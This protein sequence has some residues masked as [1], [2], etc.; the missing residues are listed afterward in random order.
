M[1]EIKL[2]DAL[3]QGYIHI[4]DD[5]IATRMHGPKSVLERAAQYIRDIEDENELLKMIV[6]RT[7]EDLHQA[8]TELSNLQIRNI[9]GDKHADQ[10]LHER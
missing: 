1:P 3:E 5:G 10:L 9:I 4:N 6:R 8:R 2:A 7:Q